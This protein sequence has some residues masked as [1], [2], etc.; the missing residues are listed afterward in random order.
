M[1]DK[2]V[3]LSS[4]YDLMEAEIILGRLK[5]NDIQCFI[6]DDNVMSANP[7]YNQAMGGIKIKVFE[8]DLELCRQVLGE[9]VIAV[10]NVSLTTCPVCQST[11]VFYGPAPATRNWLSIAISTLFL[12]AYPVYLERTWICKHCGANFKQGEEKAN[13][14]V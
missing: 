3:T 9:E 1:Q 11:D 10:E 12:G 7:F 13:G 8:H 14:V 2:I 6:A 4:Y 5:A